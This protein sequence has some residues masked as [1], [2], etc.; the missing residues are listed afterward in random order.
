MPV[1]ALNEFE[2]LLQD[3]P[4]IM[5]HSTADMLAR[6]REVSTALRTPIF[7]LPGIEPPKRVV[8]PDW[9]QIGRAYRMMD[10]NV[11]TLSAVRVARDGTD[12]DLAFD[13]E[14]APYATTWPLSEFI[15]RFEPYERPKPPRTAWARV[16]EESDD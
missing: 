2:R 11:A 3:I 4:R 5:G 16:L 15:A 8:L 1:A 10:G 14:P 7:N 13:V 6:F 9:V 12:V